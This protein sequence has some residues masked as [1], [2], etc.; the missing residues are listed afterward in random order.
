MSAGGTS[1]AWERLRG[2]PGRTPLRVRLITAVLA[3]VIIALAV[4]SFAGI[5]FLR[6][7][8]LGQADNQLQALANEAATHGFPLN[9]RPVPGEAVTWIPDG[10]QPQQAIVPVSSSGY[11]LQ[12][13]PQ[14]IPGPGIPAI[15]SSLPSTADH[16]IT[17]PATSGGGRWRTIGVASTGPAA[18]GTQTNGTLVIAIDVSGAY[19]TIGRLT[20][21]DLIV[22][23]IVIVA[24][25]IVGVAVIRASLRPLTDIEHTA[26]GIAAGDL[27]RRVPD[28]D[29]RTEVGRLGAVAERHARADRDRVRRPA[30]VGVRRPPVRGADAAVRRRRQPRAAHPADGDPR[31]RRV[32][33]A[34]RRAGRGLRRSGPGRFRPG[35]FRPGARRRQPG[36]CPRAR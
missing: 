4:I 1:R 33:P 31:L 6:S 28:H 32:L 21:I 29:P 7:Y 10:G 25:A 22:S 17:V 8:L 23:A 5:S 3:L 26:E 14:L 13:T 15:P 35:R 11:G 24:L 30:P 18:D 19:A 27:T 36:V 34:A 20:G 16:A 2:L 9:A 12:Q